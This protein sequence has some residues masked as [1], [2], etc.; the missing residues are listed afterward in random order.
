MALGLF[1]AVTVI[2]SPR[3]ISPSH[4]SRSNVAS[5]AC[6]GWLRKR[7]NPSTETIRMIAKKEMNFPVWNPLSPVTVDSIGLSV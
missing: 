4:R 1:V 5:T 3:Q 6:L 7:F 2:A